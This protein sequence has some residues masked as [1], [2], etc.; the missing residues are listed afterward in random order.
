MASGWYTPAKTKVFKGDLDFDTA[1]V[2]VLIVM[3]NTTADTEMDAANIAAFTTLDEYDGTGYTRADLTTP[4]VASD[5]T[6]DRVEVDYDDFTFGATVGAGARQGV[7]LVI[8]VRVD[9]T[10]ANDYPV[11]FIDSASNP[12]Q[13]TGGPLNVTVNAQGLLWGS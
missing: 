1:D 8:Y 3:S 5:T 6:N 12:F 7:G 2:R 10:T 13:G 11:A 4:A 9:G